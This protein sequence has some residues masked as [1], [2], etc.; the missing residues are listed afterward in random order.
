MSVALQYN[1][2]TIILL[3][4]QYGAAPRASLNDIAVQLLEHAKVE[5][6]TVIQKLIDK[7]IIKLTLKS[8]YVAA[9][10]FAF[11]RGS[12]ELA[13]R[14]ISNSNIEQLYSDA[15]YYSAKNNWPAILTNVLGKGVD[16]NVLTEGQTPLY[17]ACKE[18]HESVVDLLLNNGA[19]PNVPNKRATLK[20]F[21]L[22]LQ[23]AAKRGNA[24]VFDKL[25]QNGAKVD[26]AREPLLHIACSGAGQWKNASET[27]E[28]RYVEHIL[29]IIRLL[30]QKE[31]NVNALSDRGDTALYRACVSQQLQVVQI[32]LDAGADVNLTSKRLYPLIAAACDFGNVELI[33]LLVNAGADVK[34]RNSNN[35]TC[36]HAAV[37]ADLSTTDS[38]KTADSVLQLDIVNTI[39]SLLE[40]GVDVNACCSQ[41]ETVL[42]RASKAGHEVIVRL[43]LEE[44]AEPNSST[45]RR[46]LYAACEHGYTEIVDLLLQYGADSNALSDS[47]QRHNRP[48]SSLLGLILTYAASSGSSGLPICCAVT[49]GYTD[50]VNLLLKYGS[51]VNKQDR[52]GKSAL[53]YSIESL[54]SHKQDNSKESNLDILK[55]ILLAGGDVNKPRQH[56][57]SNALHIA[58][59][60][61]M[62]DVMMELIRHGA[63]CNYLTSSGKSVVDIAAE[64]GHNASVEL[65][66]KN[67]ANLG[68]ESAATTYSGHSRYD[69]YQTEMPALCAAAKNGSET[70]VAMLLKHGADVNVSDQNNNTALHLARSNA[71]I[72]ERLLNAGANVNATN[73]KGETVLSA[74]CE[75][76]ETDTNVAEMLLKFGADTNIC[77]PLHSACKNKNPDLIRLLLAYG[78]DANRAK[79]SKQRSQQFC[80]SSLWSI[81]IPVHVQ[82]AEPSPLCIACKNGN[83]AVVDCLLQNGADATFV[84]GDGNSVLHFAVQRLGQQANAEEYIY[85]PLI[86]LLLQHIPAVN[87]VSSNGETPLYAACVKGLTG[88]VKQLL[89]CR[90]DV[91]LTTSN[92]NKYPLLIACERKYR[93]IAIMLLDRGADANASKNKETPLKLAAANGDSAVVRKLLD[94][95]AD[96]NQMQNISDTALHAA[97]VRH[98]ETSVKI[99]EML[100]KSGAESNALNHRRETP[101][102]LACTQT[103]DAVNVR[104]VETLLKH[105]ADPNNFLLYDNSLPRSFYR[106]V[107]PPLSAAL[108][109]GNSELTI[110]LIKYGAR[111]DT[112][113]EFGRTALHFAIDNNDIRFAR[114]S[115]SAKSDTSTVEILL[116]AGADATVTDSNG[117]SPL[118]LACKRGNTEVVKLL[119]SRAVSPNTGNTD[120]HPIHAACQCQHYDSVKLL[121]EYNADVTVRD[122]DGKTA[123]LH[124][125]E[126]TPPRHRPDS[127]KRSVLAQLLLDKGADANATSNDGDTPFYV[128]CSSGLTSVVAKMLECR[129]KVDRN[130]GKKLPLTAACRYR[131]LS[132]VQLL[133]TNGA[134]TN[135]MEEGNVDRYRPTLPLHIATYDDNSELVGLLLKHGANIDVTDREGN[136]AL[137]HAVEHYRQRSTFSRYSGKV[138]ASS[139]AKPVLDI[140]LENKADL[141]IVNNSGE[142]PL[143]RAA[144]RGMVDVVRKMLQVYGGDPNRG[145]PLAAACLTQNVELAGMML[146]HGADPNVASTNCDRNSK[147]KFSLLISA[148]K[149]NSELVEL[150]LKHGANVD[151][152]DTDGNT[153]LHHAI[154]HLT[155]SPFS[156]R[157]VAAISAKSVLDT[158]LKNKADVNFVNSSGETPLYRAALRKMVDVVGK[159]LQVY[160]GDPNK[161]SPLAAACLT[162]NVELADML[163]K[164][165]ADPNLESTSCYPD[166]KHKLP[167]FVAVDKGNTDIV[168]SLLN[169]GASVNA[170]NHEGRNAVCFV[171][172]QL[173]SSGYYQEQ[174]K[175]SVIHLLIQQGASFNTLMPDG[176]SPLYL[177]VSALTGTQRRGDLYRTCAI[178]LLQLMVKHGAMLLDSSA[179]LE[180]DV[181]RQSLNSGTLKALSTFDV[182]HQ[183][184]V[185]LFRAGA[186]FQLLTSFCNAVETVRPRVAKSMCLCQ[187]AVLAGYTVSSEELQNLQLA[188]ANDDLL[189]QL[190]NW[191]NEDRQQPPSLLRQCRVVIRRQLSAAVHY[192]TILPAIDKLPLPNDMKHYLQFDGKWSEV[193]FSVHKEL[194]TCERNERSTDSSSEYRDYMYDYSDFRYDYDDYD[195]DYGNYYYGG[196]S[197]DR[198]SDRDSDDNHY[199][200]W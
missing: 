199:A 54:A 21:T 132:V 153:A 137:H 109:R 94:C 10:S 35:E 106:G 169:A 112:C 47:S 37:N 155:V 145:S 142:T 32:L 178:E 71:T 149:G 108:S 181:S 80:A 177:V 53:I 74:L 101:L 70:M 194:Q 55:S 186:G 73:S 110:L 183:F 195:S 139:N 40:A 28:T 82:Y 127:D 25:L 117:A 89:D 121:L 99:V 52:C 160:G 161:G 75:K 5:H 123:L 43:L 3:L 175:L 81:G 2:Y 34:C 185:D 91:N 166:S 136:T 15:V 154:E 135:A 126:F 65:L 163:L 6:A 147:H 124:A 198:Y 98:K 192:Q 20:D 179:Q 96:A 27:G 168:T 79:L 116:S 77:F 58:S 144:S 78:A 92:S 46:P 13:E 156:G 133:L 113:D 88:V 90:A 84:D 14:I 29:S 187:A 61:G 17:V 125:L 62:C 191:L 176:R 83:A 8:I 50:I 22:P 59:S 184:I 26:Q 23:A 131:H 193:D 97:V 174:T 7:N 190:V 151:I 173:T 122:K 157:S 143:Y 162:Q 63:N 118:Y 200:W 93:E 36:L 134:D 38:Q 189:D 87:V 76:E 146:K 129:A 57:G 68:R 66:L 1:H 105:E 165:G 45:S 11:E 42:F 30:L 111:V 130:N 86:A 41:G 114:D 24:V 141:S 31:V 95:G 171:A 197:D 159:M 56:D 170:V 4:L 67:G 39:K 60:F 115:K 150:L 16:V 148:D 152:A 120:K 9:F 12:V 100:L 44:G 182:K 138:M 103:G 19:D 72:I 180:D 69:P 119:L 107:L 49:K 18:G 164:H 33:N 85:D 188:A 64:N 172:E 48:P 104:V 102:Y 196:D 128:A 51:D 167:L 140:L 158:L